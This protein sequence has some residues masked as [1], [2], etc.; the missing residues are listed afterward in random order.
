MAVAPALLL[1]YL[2]DLVVEDVALLGGLVIL[3]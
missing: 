1:G 3:P 2:V